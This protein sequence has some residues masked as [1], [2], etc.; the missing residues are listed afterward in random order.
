MDI[1]L[2]L[3][4][5]TVEYDYLSGQLVVNGMKFPVQLKN[6]EQLLN[7]PNA[8]DAISITFAFRTLTFRSQNP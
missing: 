8:E 4:A 6:L 3:T 7:R 2:K 1:D 5:D